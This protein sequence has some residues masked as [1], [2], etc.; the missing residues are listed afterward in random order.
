MRPSARNPACY[1]HSELCAELT[2]L[3][4]YLENT[5]GS[6]LKTKKLSGADLALAL[7]ITHLAEDQYWVQQCALAGSS[8]PAPATTA[9]QPFP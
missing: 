7:A 9:S 2:G 1:Y 6:K 5:Y 8:A 4:R 3:C